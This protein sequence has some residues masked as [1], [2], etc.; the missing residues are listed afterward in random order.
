MA[1]EAKKKERLLQDIQ[2]VRVKLKENNTT[3]ELSPA[4]KLHLDLT[5]SWKSPPLKEETSTQTIWDMTQ[6]PHIGGI[7]GN[8]SILSPQELLLGQM[9]LDSGNAGIFSTWP[10]PGVEDQEK[11]RFFSQ[12]DLLDRNYPGGLSRY[13][14]NA[15]KLLSMSSRGESALDGWVPS[16]PAGKTLEV[17]TEEYCQFEYIGLSQVQHCCFVVPAGGLGERLGFSGVKFALPAEM[18]SETMIIEVYAQYILAFQ[19]FVNQEGK[20]ALC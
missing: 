17:G 18:T 5:N 1:F 9:L 10:P 8:A 12:I 19:N 15:R 11:H 7:L 16:V 2:T 6:L 4:S 13:L 3:S 20:R 14:D